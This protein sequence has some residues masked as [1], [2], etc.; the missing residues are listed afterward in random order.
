MKVLAIA[1]LLV[2]TGCHTCPV[3]KEQLILTVPEE[4]ME[5]PQPLKKL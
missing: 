4:L 1:L 5:K 2:L 3:Q